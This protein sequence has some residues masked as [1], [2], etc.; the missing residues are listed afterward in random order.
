MKIYRVIGPYCGNAA[1]PDEFT[2]DEQIDYAVSVAEQKLIDAF[3]KD[4]KTLEFDYPPKGPFELGFS[5]K[6]ERMDPHPIQHYR[7]KKLETDVTCKTCSLQYSIYGVFAFCPDCREHNSLQIFQKNMEVVNKLIDLTENLE[8]DLAT[9]LIE[10]ALENCVSSFD[11]YGRELC[12]I[13]AHCAS[14]SSN[15]KRIY[16]QNLDEAQAS[17][18]KAFGFD[19]VRS[20]ENDAWFEVRRLFQMRHVIAHKMGVVDREYINRSGDTSFVE[21]QKLQLRANHVR[22]LSD[23]LARAANKIYS[24]FKLIGCGKS[25]EPDSVLQSGN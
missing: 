25:E 14:T 3:Y 13:Y 21:G 18:R 22:R 10:N 23:L 9:R 4:L 11:G 16:F 2:T 1:D 20:F 7:E 15:V 5:M 19:L 17:V 8:E 6:V 12:R 24:E